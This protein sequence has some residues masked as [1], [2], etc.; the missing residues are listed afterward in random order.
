MKRRK[1]EERMNK[2]KY[3]VIL[4]VCQR[5]DLNPHALRQTILNRSCMPISPLWRFKLKDS[6]FLEENQ[7][8]KD[9]ALEIRLVPLQLLVP[10]AKRLI[11]YRGVRCQHER[12]LAERADPDYHQLGRYGRYG[13]FGHISCHYL[14]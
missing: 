3:L 9:L 5:R 10:Y 7:I 1:K 8:K 12:L 2:G 13:K 6:L 11:W 4:L 14:R